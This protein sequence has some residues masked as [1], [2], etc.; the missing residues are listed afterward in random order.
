MENSLQIALLSDPPE[1]LLKTEGLHVAGVV[2]GT[3]SR[4]KGGHS[5]SRC[6]RPRILGTGLGDEPS[7]SVASARLPSA[8]SLSPAGSCRRPISIWCLVGTI[9]LLTA[10]AW[11]TVLQRILFVRKQLAARE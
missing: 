3:E 6:L 10:T 5:R 8:S 9:A 7:S 2:W 4:R 1:H 11:I